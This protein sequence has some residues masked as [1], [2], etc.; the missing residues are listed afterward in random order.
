MKRLQ[1]SRLKYPYEQEA[2][3]GGHGE[4]LRHFDKIFSFLKQHFP[5][6]GQAVCD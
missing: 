6:S 2:Y 5:V 1:A 4:P 3:A